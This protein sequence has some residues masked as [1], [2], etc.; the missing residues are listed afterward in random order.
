[1]ILV[2]SNRLVGWIERS[3]LASQA[4]EFKTTDG[5]DILAAT[6]EKQLWLKEEKQMGENERGLATGDNEGEPEKMEVS[7]D[8]PLSEPEELA[9]GRASAS[10][11]DHHR[12]MMAW[13]AA[14]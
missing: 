9:V 6:S 11:N 13:K 1:M 2:V 10:S 12:V 8:D 4:P 14:E 7:D 3:D 5:E